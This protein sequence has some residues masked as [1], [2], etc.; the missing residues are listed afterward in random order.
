M[1]QRKML[2]KK[3]TV[4]DGI[5]YLV[6]VDQDYG[7]IHVMKRDYHA[8]CVA[9]FA[10]H[11]VRCFAVAPRDRALSKALEVKS[12]SPN[13][14]LRQI[15]AVAAREFL[16]G[17]PTRETA[18]MLL[19]LGMRDRRYPV[20]VW[21]T[22]DQNIAA[23]LRGVIYPFKRMGDHRI[24]IRIPPIVTPRARWKV[25]DEDW[26]SAYFWCSAYAACFPRPKEKGRLPLGRKKRAPVQTALP[27]Y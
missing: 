23:E 9:S 3:E 1:K 18:P 14:K 25:T 2:L 15:F 13:R 6:G 17:Y 22:R 4:V 24:G 7:V 26:Q 5:K 20:R 10:T 16:R 19:S 8:F 12:W 11:T 21:E 27:L